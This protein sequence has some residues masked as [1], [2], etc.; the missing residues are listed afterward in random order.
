MI[1]NK[2]TEQSNIKLKPK[3]G[4]IFFFKNSEKSQFSRK[5]K[6]TEKKNYV[7]SREG[8]RVERTFK[9]CGTHLN[10]FINKNQKQ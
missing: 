10:S 5:K 7:M 8:V 6:T 9:I 4:K 3:P 2:Q 1:S